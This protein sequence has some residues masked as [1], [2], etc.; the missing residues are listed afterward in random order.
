MEEDN[1]QR[2]RDY[3]LKL[4]SFRPRSTNEIS[5]KLREY[6]AKKKFPQNLSD[7]V[8][9]YLKKQKFI[10]DLEFARWWIDQ[11]H[12]FKPKGLLAIKLELLNKGI[13]KETISEALKGDKEEKVSE[14][15]LATKV[16]NKKII[17]FKKLSREKMIMKIRDLLLRHGFDWDTIHKVI[18][19]YVQK[20]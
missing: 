5:A 18:D 11:R 2:L 14:Y 6:C 8:I 9:D 4:L 3:S 1:Y 12:S 7:K 20:A 15:D 13:D 10:D 17:L 16:I 19:S